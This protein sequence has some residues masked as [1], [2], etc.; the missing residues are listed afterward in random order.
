MGRCHLSTNLP[1]MYCIFHGL[2]FSVMSQ[3]YFVSLY[4]YNVSD[5][6]FPFYESI[7]YSIHQAQIYVKFT[8]GM[9]YIPVSHNRDNK[10][11][12]PLHH[13]LCKQ[14]TTRQQSHNTKLPNQHTRRIKTP[15]W[16]YIYSQPSLNQPSS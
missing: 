10:A 1:T 14:K 9:S 4:V 11:H 7:L 15:Y 16:H 12:I 2:S 8:I 3:P 13:M 5:S 6:F